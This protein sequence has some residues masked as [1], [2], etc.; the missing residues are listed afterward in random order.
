MEEYSHFPSRKTY[1]SENDGI[2]QVN[3]AFLMIRIPNPHTVVQNSKFKY[4]FEDASKSKRRCW[5]RITKLLLIVR[6]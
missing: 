2:T 1:C 3:Y 4:Q 6:C 5:I